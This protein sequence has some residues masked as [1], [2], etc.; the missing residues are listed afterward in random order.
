MSGGRSPTPALTARFLAFNRQNPE[1]RE[2]FF[3]FAL[4][5]IRRGYRHYS[6]HGIL[7]RVRLE[8]VG[9]F[10]INNDWSAFYARLFREAY[11]QYRG[12]FR[13]R[14]SRADPPR[15]GGRGPDGQGNLFDDDE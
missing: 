3:A 15:G 7:Y 8:Q 11:P 1:V 4:G 13:F 14:I 10:K 2:Q 6:A 5:L 12:F 9:L